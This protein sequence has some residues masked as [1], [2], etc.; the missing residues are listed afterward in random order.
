V[1]LPPP[2]LGADLH[3]SATAHSIEANVD[4]LDGRLFVRITLDAMPRRDQIDDVLWGALGVVDSQRVEHKE[5]GPDVFPP[6][7]GSV[8]EAD[9]LFDVFGKLHQITTVAVDNLRVAADALVGP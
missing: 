8:D 2:H 7:S 3:G 9:E 5:S 1:V 6:A 4:R